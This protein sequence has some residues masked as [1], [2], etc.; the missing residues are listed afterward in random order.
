MDIS[1]KQA[2]LLDVPAKYDVITSSLVLHHLTNLEK[3]NIV[4]QIEQCLTNK[5]LFILLDFDISKNL[6]DRFAFFFVRC[7]DGFNRTKI[8]AQGKLLSLIVE[9]TNLQLLSEETYKTIAG[10]L[11]LYSFKKV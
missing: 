2:K 8:H 11:K 7:L 10:T 1:L 4:C 3:E 9:H 5:G 6:I